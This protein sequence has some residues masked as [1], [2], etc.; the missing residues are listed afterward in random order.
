MSRGLSAANQ[1]EVAATHLQEV[2]LVKFEFDTPA[3]M[4][5]GMGTI[6]FDGN[7]YLGVGDFSTSGGSRESESLGPLTMT[8]TL[9]AVDSTLLAEAVD[10][11]N[12]GD[13]ITEYIGYRN[14][15]GTLVADPWIANKGKYDH[16]SISLGT[17]NSI[18]ITAH[19]DLAV[20]AEIDGRKF[21][22]E[23]QQAEYTGDLGLEHAVAAEFVRLVWGGGPVWIARQPGGTRP[24][25]G[26]FPHD[27]P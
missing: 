9:S 24:F 1:T 16:A 3:Y 10:S 13:V 26:G 6:T 8:Y 11:G 4:H 5:N 23:D 7:D 12:F 17:D 18:T 25:G 19:H 27:Q 14:D 2:T 15:D 22:D 20:L 21:S